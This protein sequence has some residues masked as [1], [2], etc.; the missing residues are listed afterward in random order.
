MFYQITN[1]LNKPYPFPATTKAKIIISLGFG[2]F[3]FLFLLLFKPFDFTVL[4]GKVLYYALA[5]GII[6]VVMMLVN[7]FFLPL[8]LPKFFKSND[9]V[10]YKMILF[11]V[12]L[13]LLISMTNWFFS[14]TTFE[15]HNIEAHDFSF[16]LL[17]TVSVGFFPLIL[18]LFISE[19]VKTK[20]YKNIAANILE[21]KKERTKAYENKSIEKQFIT[22]VGD[23]KKEEFKVAMHNL[24]F[25]NSEK[26]YASI[27]YLEKNQVKE[28]L[29][30]TTLTK[31]EE[32]T[33]KYKSIVRCHKSYIVNANKVMKI[34]GNARSFL[35]KIENPSDSNNDFLIP[36]SRNFPKE[37]LFTLIS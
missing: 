27:F 29:L 26:N 31:I 5:Y 10:I 6:T 30:R 23:N 3:I 35:L 17:A 32:Q 19:R 7:L 4:E 25:I 34:Q 21:K 11:V 14:V 18:Y 20:Q 37:L 16:F 24:L 9:W 8:L 22:L 36:V 33:S 28:H 15:A 2:K 12:W 13:L 1:W